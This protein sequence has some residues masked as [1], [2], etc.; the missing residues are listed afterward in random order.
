MFFYSCVPCQFYKIV[1]KYFSRVA[2]D[3]FPYI[4]PELANCF[5]S[6]YLIEFDL[7]DSLKIEETKDDNEKIKILHKY[8]DKAYPLSNCSEMGC[9]WHVYC[10]RIKWVW[11]NNLRDYCRMK[12]AILDAYY[13]ALL[14]TQ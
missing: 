1:K 12:R 7:D 11:K 5:Q 14:G 3:I 8:L 2:L 6:R 10:H 9:D 4:T 13:D